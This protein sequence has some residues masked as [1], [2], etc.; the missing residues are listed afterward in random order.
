MTM[1]RIDRYQFDANE[2]TI[3]WKGGQQSQLAA[4]WLRDHCQMPDS[5]DPVSGQRLL[6]IT[7]FPLNVTIIGVSHTD[8]LLII[9]FAPEHRSEFSVSWLIKN[10]YCINDQVDDRS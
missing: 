1:K 9:D 4:I 10:C 7:D 8:D 3:D 2:L 6:N 5:R